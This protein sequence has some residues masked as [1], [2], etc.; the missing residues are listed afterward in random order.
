MACR[1]HR[2]GGASSPWCSRRQPPTGLLDLLSEPSQTGRNEPYHEVPRLLWQGCRASSGGPMSQ[3][4]LDLRRFLQ[5][6]WRYPPASP[7]PP[8]LCPPPISPLSRPV[9]PLF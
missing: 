1:S 3:Q 6:V 9:P 7:P 8:A 2:M 5:A 4:E